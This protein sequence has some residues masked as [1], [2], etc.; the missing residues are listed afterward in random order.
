MGSPVT[1]RPA[2]FWAYGKE[3]A[4]EKPP[5]PA[6]QRDVAPPF[7]I[8]D[9]DWKLLAGPRGVDPQL[10]NVVADPGET[11]DVAA[12]QPAIRNRLLTKLRAWMATLP[13]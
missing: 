4:A 7:A 1:Q 5:Q 9:G 8:R 3:G 11:S 6:Q 10:Y 12:G 2:L 13:K